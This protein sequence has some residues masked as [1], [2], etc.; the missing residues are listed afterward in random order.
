MLKSIEFMA[1]NLI[2]NRFFAFTPLWSELNSNYKSM[3]WVSSKNKFKKNL[4]NRY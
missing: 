3:H 2:K 4:L 1:A